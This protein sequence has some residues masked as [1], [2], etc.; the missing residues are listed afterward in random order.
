LRRA[1]AAALNIIP[2]TTG[3]ARVVGTVIPALKGKLRTVC[4]AC[5]LRRYRSSTHGGPE[6]DVTVEEVNAAFKK[7]SEGS[8]GSWLT[9]RNR[10]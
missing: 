4:C 7:A 9:R 8:P 2:T 1:R 3:A 5:R 6:R 10:S